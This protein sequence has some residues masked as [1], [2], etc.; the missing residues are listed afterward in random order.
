MGV[1]AVLLAEPAHVVGVALDE[2]VALVEADDHARLAD[3]G[4]RGLRVVADEVLAAQPQLTRHPRRRNRVETAV[5][6]AV[7]GPGHPCRVRPAQRPVKVGVR[8]SWNAVM[9]SA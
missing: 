7:V 1:V 6:G 3:A 2:L 9:P 5:A 4:Q 8:L